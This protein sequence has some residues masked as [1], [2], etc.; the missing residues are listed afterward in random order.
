MKSADGIGSIEQR[1]VNIA[2]AASLSAAAISMAR[3]H[4]ALS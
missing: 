1:S 4:G 3:Q 2:A